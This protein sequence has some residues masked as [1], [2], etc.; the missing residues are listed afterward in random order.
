MDPRLCVSEGGCLPI[1]GGGGRGREPRVEAP[2][3]RRGGDQRALALGDR[4]GARGG[5]DA[6]GGTGARAG[7]IAV[8]R[9]A[10]RPVAATTRG[11]GTPRRTQHHQLH[12]D[13]PGS[14]RSI[15]GCYKYTLSSDGITATW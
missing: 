2:P 11:G 12:T 10:T 14:L 3:P 4:V 9:R 13:R 1:E 15:L 5:A 7:G 6:Q 8:G